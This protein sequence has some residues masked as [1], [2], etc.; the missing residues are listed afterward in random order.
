ML[1]FVISIWVE[2]NVGRYIVKVNSPKA[3][4]S[5]SSVLKEY[6]GFT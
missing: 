5:E 1:A 3:F 2:V 4:D 6:L